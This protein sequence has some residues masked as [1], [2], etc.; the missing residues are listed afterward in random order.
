[1][2]SPLF[3][4]RPSGIHGLGLFANQFI[5]AG[6]ELG[7]LKGEPTT[8]DGPYVLWLDET[9][10]FRV[11]NDLRYI[12]HDSEPNAAYYDD[13]TVAAIADIRPGQEI[14]HHYD[15]DDMEHDGEAPFDEF[16]ELIDTDDEAVDAA[17]LDTD[18]TPD[19]ADLIA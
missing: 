5:P 1:M 2:S 3:I 18:A 12:N 6:T 13:L 7:T 4:V 17:A 14:T 11:E 15:G 19:A 8:D 10:G 9:R 16:A